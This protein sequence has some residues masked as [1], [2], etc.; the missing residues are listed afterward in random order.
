MQIYVRRT[1]I[2]SHSVS[3]VGRALASISMMFDML[4]VSVSFLVLLKKR[5]DGGKC[6]LGMLMALCKLLKTVSELG[7]FVIFVDSLRCF[8]NFLEKFVKL[9]FVDLC[10]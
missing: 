10:W 8:E 1:F 6:W 3:N 9:I 7:D 2:S 4:V 5:D